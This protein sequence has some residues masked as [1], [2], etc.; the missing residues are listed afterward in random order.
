VLFSYNLLAALYLGYLRIGGGFVSYLL[1][2]ACVVHALLAFLP[3]R[4][5]QARAEEKK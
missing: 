1:L 5:A 3:L 2:P 4:P